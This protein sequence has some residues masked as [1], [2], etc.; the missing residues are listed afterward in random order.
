MK[1][2]S[3]VEHF[4]D[5]RGDFRQRARQ[6]VDIVVAV[7][8]EFAEL[9]QVVGHNRRARN[10]MWAE[11]IHLRRLAAGHERRG[12]AREFVLLLKFRNLSGEAAL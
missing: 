10:S 12:D 1:P 8:L 3:C 5:V 6:D 7:H 2:S 4:G 11:R 9:E